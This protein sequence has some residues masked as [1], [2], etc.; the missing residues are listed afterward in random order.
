MNW[1]NV[2]HKTDYILP[3]VDV[4]VDKD[5]GDDVCLLVSPLCTGGTL[6]QRAPMLTIEEKVKYAYELALAIQACHENG[7]LHAD[8]KP[9][10]ILLHN[11]NIQLCDFGSSVE[12]HD[13][14][15]SGIVTWM[16]LN[17]APP[18]IKQSN[19]VGFAADVWA[20][21]MTL[22]ELIHDMEHSPYEA[23]HNN[24]LRWPKKTR[25]TIVTEELHKMCAVVLGCL[26]K[27]PRNRITMDEALLLLR[28]D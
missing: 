19:N 16:T 11:G 18:E 27:H 9:D 3:L 7:V 15:E 26:E 13:L 8:I 2:S 14:Y 25:H 10:N 28:Y 1:T 22:F 17:Y 4:V 20:F 6:R 5:D 23:H 24:E 12:C 21:G